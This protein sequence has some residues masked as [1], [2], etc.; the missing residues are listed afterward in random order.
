VLV[1]V[2]SR[3]VAQLADEIGGTAK[4]EHALLPSR[5]VA[6]EAKRPTHLP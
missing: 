5:D 2:R 3:F 6:R 1:N 4:H